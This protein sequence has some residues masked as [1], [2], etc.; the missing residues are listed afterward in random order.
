MGIG[1]G[2]GVGVGLGVGVGVGVGS[3]VGVGEG[4]SVAEGDGDGLLTVIAVLA[5]AVIQKQIM[6]INKTILFINSLSL[7]LILT[8]ITPI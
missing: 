4:V 7:Y 5:Q 1:V 6:H 3:D 2:V 8:C